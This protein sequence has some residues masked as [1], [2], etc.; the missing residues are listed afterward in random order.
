M[1]G[2]L[3]GLI[4][5]TFGEEEIVTPQVNPAYCLLHRGDFLDT[6]PRPRQADAFAPVPVQTRVGSQINFSPSTWT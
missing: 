1:G 6:G 4:I 5:Q 2:F 3:P